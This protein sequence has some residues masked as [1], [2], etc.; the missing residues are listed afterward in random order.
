MRYI[1]K[2]KCL[3]TGQ[4]FWIQSNIPVLTRMQPTLRFIRDSVNKP[5][6]S[7]M[8]KLDTLRETLDTV[9][10]SSADDMW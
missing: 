7:K 8:A 4:H 5:L 10:E 6:V 2:L 9:W 1:L 3:E